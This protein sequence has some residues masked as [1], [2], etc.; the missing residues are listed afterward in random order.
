LVLEANEEDLR[1][2]NLQ[3]KDYER[4]KVPRMG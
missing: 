4:A 3:D 1:A 2:Q